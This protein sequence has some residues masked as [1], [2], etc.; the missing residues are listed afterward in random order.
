MSSNSQFNLG[1]PINTAL[2]LF[3][4]YS[5]QKIILPTIPV[6]LAPSF[7]Q[8]ILTNVLQKDTKS[9]KKEPTPTEF[10]SGY[11]WSP[12]THPPTVL[13]KT[14]TP[15]TLQPFNGVDNPRILLAI[16]GTVFDVS[17]GRNFYGPS[18]SFKLRLSHQLLIQFRQMEC[19][20][21]L[22]VVMLLAEWQSNPSIRVRPPFLL[23]SEI[24]RLNPPLFCLRI[25]YSGLNIEMLTAIDQ[26]LDKLT[27]LAPDEM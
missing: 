4:L 12:K 15:K 24:C 2:F 26:P 23:V 9:K 20:E 21:T 1:S 5:V 13:F 6:S 14:Y 18:E 7:R 3:I 27:D 8:H 10:K 25:N 11:T 19:T 17:A 22:R 16:N